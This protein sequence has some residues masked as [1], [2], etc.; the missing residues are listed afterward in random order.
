MDHRCG[1]R[2]GSGFKDIFIFETGVYD[3]LEKAVEIME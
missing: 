2:E 1:P 3:P